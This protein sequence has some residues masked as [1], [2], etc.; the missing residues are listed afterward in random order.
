VKRN[1]V[2][3]RPARP[4]DVDAVFDLLATSF[5]GY[6]AFSP[7]DWE[8]PRPEPDERLSMARAFE[9]PDVWY[10]VAS[11]ANGH[12]GQCGFVP[13]HTERWFQGDAIEGL[14][15]FW[16]LF[17]RPDMFGT[18]LADRLHG[19]A[20]DKIR[21][22]GFARARLWTPEGQ[23][24]ARRFYEKRGWYLNGEREDEHGALRIP[25]VMYVHDLVS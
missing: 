20:L 4:D 16:Q 22:R 18:G 3:I 1:G 7:P 25:I 21:A 14:A 12:A 19:M 13:A 23:A 17:V 24:R 11:D 6:R 5:D 8:P 2:Q 10:V 9:R 15:H